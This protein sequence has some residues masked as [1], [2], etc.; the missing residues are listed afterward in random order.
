MK[1]QPKI[2]I[3]IL[4]AAAAAAALA[5]TQGAV[6]GGD[7]WW[8]AAVFWQN[9]LVFIIPMILGFGLIELCNRLFLAGEGGAFARKC[10]WWA[11]GSRLAFLTLAPIAMLLWGYASNRDLKGLIQ[12]DA[13]N[14]V[15]TAWISAQPGNS[16]LGAFHRGP[17][18][19]T[20][21]ITMMGVVVFR[22]LSM[23]LERTLLLGLFASVLTSLTVIAVYRLGRGFFPPGVAKAAAV[24]AAVY[25]EA[26]MI[27]S[28]HQQLGYITLVFSMALLGLAGIIRN[29]E[30]AAGDPALPGRRHAVILLGSM[31]VLGFFVGYQFSILGIICAAAFALWLSD[32]KKRIGRILWIGAGAVVAVLGVIR[33]LSMLD[34]IPADWDPLFAQYRFLYGMAWDEFDKLKAAGGGDF[35]QTVLIT[36]EKAPAF[37]LAAVYGLVRPALPA[38]IGYRNTSAEGGLFWQ[39]L[40]LYRSLG[41]Y[42]LL[43]LLLYGTWKSV[44]GLLARK[45]ETILMLIFWIVALVGSYRAFGDEWDNPRY[46]LFAIAPMALL[47]AW[48]WITQREQKDPWF[49]R[50][51]IPFVTATVSLT[52]WYI[53]RDYAMLNFPAVPSIALIG[54]ITGIAFVLS[55]F[56]IRPKKTEPAR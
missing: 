53:L 42:L 32:P 19:N 7:L 12:L 55:V 48:G 10:T 52:V 4:A 24:I 8:Y 23:D 9:F 43:P 3:L 40:N 45:P 17:G 6:L 39:L 31:I 50:I 30:P 11:L 14:A 2:L 29:V 22:L 25:P 54:V 49:M 41:W 35:F 56:F 5:A 34:I 36:M 13:I 51:V 15:D 26:V 38:A 28:S 46:R 37:I 47:A 21:G 33:V 44:R 1:M 20:G 27:G 18:D 16:L